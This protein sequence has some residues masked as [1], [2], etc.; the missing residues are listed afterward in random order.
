MK[1]Y[2]QLVF[3]FL[4]GGKKEEE[5]I[6]RL[7]KNLIKPNMEIALRKTIND[8][9]QEELLHELRYRIL[10]KKDYLESLEFVSL[11]YLKTIIKNLL[12]DTIQGERLNLVSLQEKIFEEE[13]ARSITYEE[14]IK[15]Y[16]EA[17]AQ[18]EGNI[19]FEELTS[20]LKEEDIPV[21]CYYFNKSL[22]GEE[23]EIKGISRDTLY[24]RWERLRKGMLREV[25]TKVTPEE[26][27]NAVENFLSEIC[28]KRGYINN[29]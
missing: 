8:D 23:I 20:K 19:L 29:G 24:K 4:M 6:R 7:L 1:D 16:R 18:L 14:I 21:L 26:F 28:Q 11:K 25:L 3:G 27:R 15:D 5:Y 13:E 22:Y 10:L 9:Y 2:K 12:V 17:F